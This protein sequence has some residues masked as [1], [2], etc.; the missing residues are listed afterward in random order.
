MQPARGMHAGRL[1]E[2]LPGAAANNPHL[3]AAQHCRQQLS[4]RVLQAA[5]HGWS[6][7]PITLPAA[8]RAGR[9]IG[10]LVTGALGPGTKNQ[11]T[12]CSTSWSCH[13]CMIRLGKGS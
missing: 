8:R 10:V 3:P 12:A 4:V 5:H 2:L 6:L 1:A 13:C 9:T 11:A 7:A